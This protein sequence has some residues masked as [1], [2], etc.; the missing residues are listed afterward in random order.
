VPWWAIAVLAAG[1]VALVAISWPD[2]FTYSWKD[3]VRNWYV[4]ESRRD[5]VVPGAL[6]AAVLGLRWVR[7]LLGAVV[8]LGLYLATTALIMLGARLTHDQTGEWVLVLVLGVAVAAAA[9]FAGRVS[10][11]FVGP[12]HGLG[13]VLVVAGAAGALTSSA[14]ELNGVTW[15]DVTKGLAILSAALPVVVAWPLLVR[16]G[17][18]AARRLVAAAAVAVVLADGVGSIPALTSHQT[19]S[20]VVGTI[21]R[22]LV[23]VG[24]AVAAANRRETAQP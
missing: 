22:A 8:G 16:A 1:A 11:P 12:V 19:T 14:I 6:L 13:T 10:V 21:G 17:D 15:L 20:F 24:I 7:D 23:L 4:V 5:L 18:A 3:P 9:W 2:P